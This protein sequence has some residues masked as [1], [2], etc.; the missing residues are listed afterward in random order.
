MLSVKIAR[1]RQINLAQE[2][3]ISRPKALYSRAKCLNEILHLPS[4]R[5]LRIDTERLRQLFK[6]QYRRLPCVEQHFPNFDS[7]MIE[8]RCLLR[9]ER[10]T[11][12]KLA[13]RSNNI[14]KFNPAAQL[15][16]FGAYGFDNSQWMLDQFDH[17]LP[18][19]RVSYLRS[20]QA[21]G[22]LPLDMISEIQFWTVVA[23]LAAIAVL[24][25]LL[26]RRHSPRLAGLGLVIVSMVILNALVTGVLSVVDDRYECRIIWLVPLL[27]GLMALDWLHQRETASRT[28]ASRTAEEQ[29][30]VMA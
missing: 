11:A 18:A 19:A 3:R 4:Y 26:W 30:A 12:H 13:E 16:A 9:V 10:K 23:S 21:R 6:Q 27:A 24:I 5:S 1:N 28:D 17:V 22:I 7:P 8:I 20:K 15:I 14:E 29:V 2:S 25:P